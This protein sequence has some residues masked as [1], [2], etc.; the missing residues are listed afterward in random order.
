[1]PLRGGGRGQLMI[2][3]LRQFHIDENTVYIP[4]GVVIH[5]VR[6]ADTEKSDQLSTSDPHHSE[7]KHS[8]YG[9]HQQ[10]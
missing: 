4:K 9:P 10:S 2:K 1:M 8:E 7:D 5:A 3:E 6:D